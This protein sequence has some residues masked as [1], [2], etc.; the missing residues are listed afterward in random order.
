[1][2]PVTGDLT[3][4]DASELA[5]RIRSRSVSPVEVTEAFLDRIQRLNTRF[6]AFETVTA[7]HALQQA[8]D[9]DAEARMGRWRGPL[10]GVPYGAKDLLATM[11]IRTTWGARPLKEQVFEYDATVIRKLHEH[12]SPLLG[13]TAMVEFAGGLGY[14]DAH[15]SVSGPGRNPWNPERWTGGSSSGSG[16]A[17][18]ASLAPFAIG[19][20]TWGSILCPS[21]FCGLTGLRPTYGRVSRFGGMVCADTFDKIGP[22]AHTAADC[23]RVLLEIAGADPQDP[24]CADEPLDFEKPWRRRLSSL[25]AALVP[26]DF[27]VKGAEPEVKDGFERAVNDLRSAGLRLEPA[28]LPKFPASEL[29]GVLISAEAVSAFERFFR[30]GRVRRLVDPYAPYQAEIAGVITAA[31]TMK[32]WRLRRLLQEKMA[33]FFSEFDV[34][35]TPNFLSVAPLIQDDL[36]KA[37]PYSDPAGAIGNACGLPAIALPCGF[38]RDHMPVGFQIMAAPW[39][40]GVLLDLGELYQQRTRWHLER[41]SLS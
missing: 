36:V 11:G 23:R 14:R 31:D 25:R 26:M 30:D 40:E 41:P 16:A 37:L 17:V 21:A 8:H 19:T 15:A 1:V 3:A 7:D 38:G 39:D 29:A 33:K 24:T 27:S 13:K 9:A 5:S 2:S 20:E 10:H 22:L 6:N 4:L 34:V 28:A 32:A 12:A 35:V 18:S